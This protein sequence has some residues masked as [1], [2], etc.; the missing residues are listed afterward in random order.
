[1]CGRYTQFHD[2]SEVGLLLASIGDVDGPMPTMAS[3]Y[4]V[5]PSQRAWSIT[6]GQRIKSAKLSLHVQQMH[7]GFRPKFMPQGVINA[8]SETVEEKPMFRSALQARRCLVLASGFYEW[9]KGADGKKIAYHF[10]LASKKPFVFAGLYRSVGQGDPAHGQIEAEF[11]IVTTAANGCVQPVHGRMPVIMDPKGAGLWLDN[12]TP[13]LAL[14]S[15]LAPYP[16]EAMAAQKVSDLVNR[17]SND[18]PACIEP[19]SA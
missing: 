4:N 14:R 15:L 5:A 8:R 2:P 13:F 9:A 18:A 12:Q 16:A 17:P 6:H 10:T 11:V 3:R 1:M 7:F 19:S